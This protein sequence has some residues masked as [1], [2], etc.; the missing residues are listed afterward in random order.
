MM[1]Y[2]PPTWLKAAA[3]SGHASAA[4]HCRVHTG[5]L[6]TSKSISKYSSWGL[7]T[8]SPRA[9]GCIARDS[10]SWDMYALLSCKAKSLFKACNGV[11]PVACSMSG[12][13]AINSV[14]KPAWTK[15]LPSISCANFICPANTRRKNSA[16]MKP[17]CFQASRI[18]RMPRSWNHSSRFP[19]ANAPVQHISASLLDVSTLPRRPYIHEEGL[20]HEDAWAARVCS[21]K[22]PWQ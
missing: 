15:T 12:N 22:K 17:V 1:R 6:S 16:P 18:S 10:G 13:R 7:G 19:H 3:T 5:E 21:M 4:S 2:S 8:S 9:V 20:T 11:C 14:V